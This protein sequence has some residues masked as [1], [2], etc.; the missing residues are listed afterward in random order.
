M[1]CEVGLACFHKTK[2]VTKPLINTGWKYCFI[3]F[4][5]MLYWT[6]L[7]VAT[8]FLMTKNSLFCSDI[9]VNLDWH[10]LNQTTNIKTKIVFS[11]GTFL[12]SSVLSK[13]SSYSFICE[14]RAK[15]GIDEMCRDQWNW[16]SKNPYGYE[17]PNSN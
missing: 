15:Y 13:R 1:S 16:A 11:C 10:F 6:C 4:F 2:L 5:G 3:N 14:C 12:D 8:R 17:S 7:Q 9:M